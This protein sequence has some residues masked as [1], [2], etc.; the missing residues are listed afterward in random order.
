MTTKLAL[1]MQTDRIRLQLP[2][3]GRCAHKVAGT[4]IPKG[5]TLQ[6]LLRLP[7]PIPSARGLIYQEA[8]G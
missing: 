3:S 2:S 5:T 7:C 8:L 6:Y 4:I 1:P